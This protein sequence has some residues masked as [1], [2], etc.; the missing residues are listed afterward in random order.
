MDERL[1]RHQ[2]KAEERYSHLIDSLVPGRLADV[3]AKDLE[4]MEQLL[5]DNREDENF[6]WFL[7]GLA[8]DQEAET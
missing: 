8:E 5:R 1:P 4:M 6:E 7:F 3:V 2:Q